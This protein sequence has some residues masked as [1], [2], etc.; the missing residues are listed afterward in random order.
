M[1]SQQQRTLN[2]KDKSI[3]ERQYNYLVS[4][5]EM[6][7]NYKFMYFYKKGIKPVYPFLDEIVNYTPQQ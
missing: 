2:L 4:E 3:L 6:G 5:K 7:I 1:L